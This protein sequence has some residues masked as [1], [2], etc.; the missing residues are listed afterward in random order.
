MRALDEV[1]DAVA[2]IDSRRA[3]GKVALIP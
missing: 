2:L 3:V 1:G